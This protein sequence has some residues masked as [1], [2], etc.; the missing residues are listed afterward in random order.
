MIFS[1]LKIYPELE[2]P[3]PEILLVFL[4]IDLLISPLYYDP[5]F[6]CPFY[7]EST[8]HYF[9]MYCIPTA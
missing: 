7:S 2:C 4:I 1:A 6:H 5:S 8:Y 9:Y 3:L